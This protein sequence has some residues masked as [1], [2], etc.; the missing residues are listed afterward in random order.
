MWMWPMC[1]LF[2]LRKVSSTRRWSP[3]RGLTRISLMQSFSWPNNLRS[4]SPCK[5]MSVW[6]VYLL[7]RA[8]RQSVSK[9][10]LWRSSSSP[11]WVC[12]SSKIK[13]IDSIPKRLYY[14]VVMV[15]NDVRFRV[16]F[17]T[18]ARQDCNRS[19]HTFKIGLFCFVFV[20]LFV[21]VRSPGWW[22]AWYCRKGLS[23]EGCTGF[24]LWHLD[25]L[26]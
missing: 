24:V 20:F 13:T 8:G 22:R 19:I 5:L 4:L 6:C 26:T 15:H 9:N 1:A 7:C 12:L 11:V 25:L 23:K 10:D 14:C 17:A 21:T 16:V 2:W 3:L 18:Q